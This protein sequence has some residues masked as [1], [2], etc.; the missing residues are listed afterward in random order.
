M[1]GVVVFLEAQH[2]VPEATRE[3]Q[4]TGELKFNIN[5]LKEQRF[6]S[7]DQAKMMDH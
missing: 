7:A 5:R 1:E 3:E 4:A 2:N 6:I